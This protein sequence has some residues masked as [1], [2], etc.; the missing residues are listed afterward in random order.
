MLR[1]GAMSVL[2]SNFSLP[3][4]FGK[5]LLV[6]ARRCADVENQLANSGC[7]LTKVRDGHKALG[8]IRHKAF[9]TAILLSTGEQM[10]LVE[11]ILNLRDIKPSMP[12]IVL[13]D[14]TSSDANAAAQAIIA[15]AIPDV[16]IFTLS[17]FQSHLLSTTKKE[18]R[19]K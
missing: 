12:V 15:G 4:S 13:F 18:E 11:T 9:D 17:E 19:C 8:K 3:R 5:T 14:P 16:P 7:R 1:F 2:A 10:D 6:C